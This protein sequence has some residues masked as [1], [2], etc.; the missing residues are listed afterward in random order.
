MWCVWTVR[1]L[2]ADEASDWL[3]GATKKE[4]AVRKLV[5]GGLKAAVQK[6]GLGSLVSAAKN[7]GVEPGLGATLAKA[8]AAGAN[9]APM[10]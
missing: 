5:Q 9:A 2:D 8:G 6:G 1:Q 10:P 4:N 7:A 3:H